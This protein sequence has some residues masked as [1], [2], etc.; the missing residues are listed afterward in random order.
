LNFFYWRKFY[1]KIN[2]RWKI[3]EK[4]I[5]GLKI[6]ILKNKPVIFFSYISTNKKIFQ[7][8]F[9]KENKNLKKNLT[10]IKKK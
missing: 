1:R 10:K 5:T 9:N 4:N 7:S 6:L 2:Y 8:K 3:K